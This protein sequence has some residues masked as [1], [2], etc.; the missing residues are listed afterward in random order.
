MMIDFDIEQHDRELIER[1]S[2]LY[3]H[4][5]AYYE[6]EF[7]PVGITDEEKHINGIEAAIKAIY[8]LGQADGYSTGYKAGF[9]AAMSDTE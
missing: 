4:I 8:R 6:Q 7:D 2:A 9:R 3:K 1:E 5:R